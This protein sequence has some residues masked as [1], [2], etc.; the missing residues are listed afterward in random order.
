MEI[1]PRTMFELFKD[2]LVKAQM[3]TYIYVYNLSEGHGGSW[4]KEL[5][6]VYSDRNMQQWN[7]GL[8]MN[9]IM[10]GP[11]QISNESLFDK[12]FFCRRGT[13]EYLGRRW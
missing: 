6:F 2:N 13:Q 4:G 1:N 5:E 7:V 9:Y 3:L 10:N 11:I 12:S 8:L